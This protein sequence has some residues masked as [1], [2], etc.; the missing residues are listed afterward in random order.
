MMKAFVQR[1]YLTPTMKYLSILLL[2]ILSYPLQAQSPYILPLPQL[3]DHLDQMVGQ[4]ADYQQLREQKAAVLKKAAANTKGMSRVGLLQQVYA[5]Y[6]HYQTDSA[7]TALN[8]LQKM[9][10]VKQSVTLTAWLHMSQAEIWAVSGLYAEAVQEMKLVSPSMIKE[11]G[12]ELRLQYYRIQRTIY[13]WMA[14]YTHIGTY[15]SHLLTLT[16]AYRDS[17]LMVEKDGISRAVV[18]ADKALVG[19]HAQG[20]IHILK[21]F[22]GDKA[23]EAAPYINFI[24]AQA[25]AELKDED[26]SVRYLALTAMNDL[27]R[28]ITE[29]QAL[30]LLAQKLYERNDVQ[31]AY[32]YLICS[33]EDA[34]FCKARLRAVEVSNVFPIINKA[35]KEKEHSDRMREHAYIYL[36]LALLIALLVSM[37]YLYRQVKKLRVMRQSQAK[38]NEQLQETNKQMLA[39]NQQLKNTYAELRLSDKMKEEYLARYLNKCR[40]YLDRMD[41]DRRAAWRM[42]K[43]KQTEELMKYLKSDAHIKK[44]QELFYEDFDA[45]FLTLF[46]DFIRSFNALLR[47]EEP[48]LPK[49]ENRLSTELRI[50]ALIRLGVTDTARIAHFMNYSTATIYNYRSK[51]RNRSKGR[52]EDFEKEVG[53]L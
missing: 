5:T 17:L 13:G 22:V 1:K 15:H 23:G 24:L 47:P 4:K 3:L 18:E 35:Y 28:G 52:P 21:P 39:V 42:L 14:N 49:E 19:H 53:N 36:L 44:E 26:A 12:E 34:N 45:A 2:F 11:G 37:V 8:D 38:M 16:Q 33:M 32:A 30:P 25:Y 9:P 40:D 6:S 51:I 20:A 50:F 29:Y 43:D 41:D 10:E 7:Q 27:E 31:R 48:V 46:P